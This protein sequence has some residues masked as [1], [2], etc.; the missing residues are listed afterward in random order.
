MRQNESGAGKPEMEACAACSCGRL[1]MET[2]RRTF[3]AQGAAALAMMALAACG[4]SNDATAPETLPS[5]TVTLADSPE[6]NDVGG[7]LVT[8]IN[9]SPVAVVHETA[10]S[11]SAFSLI[12]PHQ[13]SIVQW[14]GASGFL[15]PG[16]GARFNL[17]GQNIG[18]QPTSSL[19]SYPVTYDASA[20]TVTIGG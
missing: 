19:R 9:G 14:E 20:G 3:I 6:L 18:G 13:G 5:T 11:F 16:H 1:S 4:M 7:V 10:S 17:A 2:S 8:R 15:C 12:C